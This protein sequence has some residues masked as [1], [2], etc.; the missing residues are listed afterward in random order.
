MTRD[1]DHIEILDTVKLMSKMLSKIKRSPFCALNQEYNNKINFA[2]YSK[3][4]HLI[5]FFFIFVTKKKKK[6]SLK[7]SF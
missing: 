6:L 2:L 1:E 4:K 7:A 3:E 5:F